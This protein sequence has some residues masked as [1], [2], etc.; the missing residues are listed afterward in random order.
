MCCCVRELCGSDTRRRDA[1]PQANDLIEEEK[2]SADL[3][4]RCGSVAKR[5]VRDA[6]ET[7]FLLY[8]VQGRRN[9]LQRPMYNTNKT[10]QGDCQHTLHT[11]PATTISNI[12]ASIADREEWPSDVSAL[13][14]ETTYASPMRC[15]M[16]LKRPRAYRLTGCREDGDSIQE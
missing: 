6:C 3:K 10:H 1:E 2:E 14:L 15:T 8:E 13:P 4:W 11:A 16:S 7:S 12:S 5:V 9:A